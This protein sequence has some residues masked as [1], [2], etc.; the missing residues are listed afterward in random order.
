MKARA[1]AI[2]LVALAAAPFAL[3]QAIEAKVGEL[4]SNDALIGHDIQVEAKFVTISG[5]QLVIR[6]G[7]NIAITVDPKYSQLFDSLREGAN[8]RLLGTIVR[9]ASGRR[10]VVKRAEKR[11][12]DSSIFK[13]ELE[14]LKTGGDAAKLYDLARRIEAELARSK[15]DPGLRPIAA[16]AYRAGIAL[17][18]KSAKPDDNAAAMRIADLYTEKLGDRQAALDRLLRTFKKGAY[19]PPEVEERL[20]DKRR[21]NAVPYGGEWVLYEEMKRREGFV[22]RGEVWMLAEHAEFLD[23]VEEQSR[24]PRSDRIKNLQSDFEL[25][26]RDGR[27]LLGMLKREVAAAIGFPDDVDRVRKTVELQPHVYDSW[28]FEGR[29][30]YI[31]DNDVLFKKP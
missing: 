21:I 3:A 2:L 31:F 7:D 14:R 30:Q 5:D 26:A 1:L 27:V 22:L 25:A 17:E 8:V 10:F 24:K 6:D 9:D 28:A 12:D 29:G 23:A 19:P 18:E 20:L 15:A 11:P 13:D 16:D 4:A